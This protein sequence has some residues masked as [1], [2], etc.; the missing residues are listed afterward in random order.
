MTKVRNIIFICFLFL[1]NLCL[2]I[3][4]PINQLFIILS[5][6]IKSLKRN[7]FNLFART[8]FFL[9]LSFLN[10][11][12]THKFKTKWFTP[13]HSIWQLGSLWSNVL[14]NAA[15]FVFIA[16]TL[17]FL[18]WIIVIWIGRAYSHKHFPFRYFFGQL[19]FWRLLLMN[20]LNLL[21]FLGRVMMRTYLC[22]TFNIF[23]DLPKCFG[24][25]IAN[26]LLVCYWWSS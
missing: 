18:N 22:I 13:F 14:E 23:T 12:F 20:L 6:L 3:S 17:T 24:K 19:K 2:I 16:I 5:I 10:I 26:L 4:L 15:R 11:A 1:H 7:T 25:S 9:I 8:T 21:Y